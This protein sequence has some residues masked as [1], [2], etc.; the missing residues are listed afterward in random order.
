MMAGYDPIAQAESG[1]MWMTGEADGS[2]TPHGRFLRRY[3]HRHVCD[4]GD[5]RRSKG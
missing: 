1:M 2:A 4:P 5:A 3:V